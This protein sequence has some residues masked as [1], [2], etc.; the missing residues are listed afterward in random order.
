MVFT[1]ISS[2]ICVEAHIKEEPFHP[3]LEPTLEN[4]V[5]MFGDYPADIICFGHN[6]PEHLFQTDNKIYAE[7]WSPWC[8]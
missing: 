8:V 2:H 6:H 5:E 4:M 1:I 7:P 3:I